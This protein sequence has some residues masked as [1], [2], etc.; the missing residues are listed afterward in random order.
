MYSNSSK[1][2]DETQIINRPTF[3]EHEKSKY[4]IMDAPTDANLQAYKEMLQ[5]R[6]CSFVVRTCKPTYNATPLFDAGIE[7]KELPFKDGAP[8]PSD[9]LDIW[10]EIIKG[11]KN[12]GSCVAVHCVA[13]LG[14]APILVAISLI[15]DGMSS[16]DAIEFIRKHRKGVFNRA[17]LNYLHKYERRSGG[18]CCVIC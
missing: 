3:L 5:K 11:Q 14:R 6:N 7:V 16:E 2:A 15:E 10:L 13:G 4:L 17:Q 18:M 9:V 1:T 12:S 8:P